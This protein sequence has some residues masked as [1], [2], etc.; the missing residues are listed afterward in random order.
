MRLPF[1]S[2]SRWVSV[3]L[4]RSQLHCHLLRGVSTI[5]KSKVTSLPITFNSI[6][7]LFRILVKTLPTYAMVSFLLA[8]W[9]RIVF[10]PTPKWNSLRA[11][12][13]LVFPKPIGVHGTWWTLKFWRESGS[14]WFRAQNPEVNSSLPHF[15]YVITRILITSTL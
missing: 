12:P 1:P 5:T 8:Y 11:E 7:Q 3:L 15:H 14:Q 13:C 10:L 6:T 9:L 2:A 4:F